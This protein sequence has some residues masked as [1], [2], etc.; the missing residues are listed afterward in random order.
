MNP[1]KKTSANQV[2]GLLRAKGLPLPSFARLNGYKPGTAKQVV[3]RYAGK[4][5]TPRGALT[6]DILENIA[7]E[8]QDDTLQN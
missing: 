6:V 1:L 8:I 3:Y 7:R 4:S 5:A 2:L